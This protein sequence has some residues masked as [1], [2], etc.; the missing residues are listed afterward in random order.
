MRRL[1]S[2]AAE[3]FVLVDTAMYVHLTPTGSL[4]I[5]GV[6]GRYFVPLGALAAATLNL[7]ISP[8]MRRSGA[9]LVYTVVIAVL[10]VNTLAMDMTI[11]NKFH[12]F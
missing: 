8:A 10:C 2:L 12:L 11:I 6:Q 3:C 5:Y 1:T 7:A 9:G 4:V